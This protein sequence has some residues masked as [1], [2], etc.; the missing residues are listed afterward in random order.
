MS[1]IKE[2]AF[3]GGEIFDR[4]CVGQNLGQITFSFEIQTNQSLFFRTQRL[5]EY[6]KF[7]Q[8]ASK[9]IFDENRGGEKSPR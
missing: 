1:R 3:D 7:S 9:N 8:V 2:S 5:I 4:C 6:Q